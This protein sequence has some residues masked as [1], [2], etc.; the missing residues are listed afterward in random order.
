MLTISI[1]LIHHHSRLPIVFSI[2]ADKIILES[3]KYRLFF[4]QIN[5]IHCEF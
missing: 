5:K 2:L 4:I 3:Q 1:H